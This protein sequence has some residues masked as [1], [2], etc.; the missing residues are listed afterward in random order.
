M[1]F[2]ES[3]ADRSALHVPVTPAASAD[4]AAAITVVFICP[5]RVAC[6]G[7]IY[8]A[9]STHGDGGP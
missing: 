5:D 4:T 1:G 2:N 3:S 9:G 6:G 7:A 8:S